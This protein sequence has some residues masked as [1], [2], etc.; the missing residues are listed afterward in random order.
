MREGALIWACLSWRLVESK[1]S[2]S[3]RLAQ[4]KS[5]HMIHDTLLRNKPLQEAC[6][7]ESKWTLDEGILEPFTALAI[8]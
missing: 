1:W 8:G 7:P 6:K 2:C 3:L 4:H 5:G